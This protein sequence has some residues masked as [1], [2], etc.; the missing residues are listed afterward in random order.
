M[1][2]YPAVIAAMVLSACVALVA[3]GPEAS[4]AVPGPTA[5]I[6]LDDSENTPTP[7]P[8]PEVQFTQAEYA[9]RIDAFARRASK[10]EFEREARCAITDERAEELMERS[11][12]FQEVLALAGSIE[13][14]LG[15]VREAEGIV[16][17]DTYDARHDRMSEAEWDKLKTLAFEFIDSV[18]V[19]LDAAVDVY[20][21][22]GCDLA[23]R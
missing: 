15:E 19:M 6:Q 10:I 21:D 9:R 23:N 7:S 8:T 5:T 4:T 12:K 14:R 22:S 1:R 17:P 16:F 2:K 18:E 11:H 13:K 20:E 3:C